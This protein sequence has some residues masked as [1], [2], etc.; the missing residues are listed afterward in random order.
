MSD[1]KVVPLRTPDM[2]DDPVTF[3]R[4]LADDIE[5]GATPN[6]AKA[7]LVVETE[8]G[9]SLWSFGAGTKS[10]LETLGLLQLGVG[11]QYEALTEGE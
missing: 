4:M 3:L 5:Q 7:V 6:Y 8:R 11:L 9:Y 2:R 10:K 1:L